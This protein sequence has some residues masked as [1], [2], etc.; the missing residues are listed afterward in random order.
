MRQR[1]DISKEGIENSLVIREYAAIGK[2]TRQLQGMT[3]PEDDYTFMCQE[4]YQ[5][6][7]IR[8]SISNGSLIA[9]LRTDNLFPIGL[10]AA[11]IAESVVA[12]YRHSEDRST[13]LFFDDSEL[14]AHG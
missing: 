7:F 8:D 10:L 12:L 2:D 5:G 4:N 1:Y 14:F 3:A 6:E 11:K 13:E 9:A